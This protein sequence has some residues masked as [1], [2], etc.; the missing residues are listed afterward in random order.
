MKTT[1]T[2]INTG[3]KTAKGVTA[4]VYLSDDA[5]LDAADTKVATLALADLLPASHGKIGKGESVSL[6]IKDKVPAAL[7]EGLKGKHLIVVLSATNGTLADAESSGTAA[8]V[9]GNY[10]VI[11][12]GL[13]YGTVQVTGTSN[14]TATGILS[15]KLG[16]TFTVTDGGILTDALGGEWT[17]QPGGVLNPVTGGI[18]LKQGGTTTLIAGSKLTLATGQTVILETWPVNA[19]SAPVVTGGTTTGVATVPTNEIVIGPIT[20]P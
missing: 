20:L 12:P 7:A 4:T 19:T 8:A 3:N 10:G 17:V 11:Y 14:S 15:M 16:D 9:N 1:A 5:V 13:G 2:V 18:L 6:P